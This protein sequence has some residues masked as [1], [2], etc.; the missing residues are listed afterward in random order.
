MRRQK[1][2]YRTVHDAQKLISHVTINHAKRLTEIC[3]NQQQQ[4][5]KSIFLLTNI[6][7]TKNGNALFDYLVKLNHFSLIAKNIL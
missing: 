2:K 4:Q 7:H 6:Q 1:N 5:Q 3:I